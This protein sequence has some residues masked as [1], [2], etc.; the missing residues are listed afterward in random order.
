MKHRN[1]GATSLEQF[2][3]AAPSVRDWA[4]SPQGAEGL[5]GA[6]PKGA[7]GTAGAASR[8]AEGLAGCSPRGKSKLLIMGFVIMVNNHA[9]VANSGQ[10]W[11]DSG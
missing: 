7:D 11:S 4:R 10:Q 9:I 5:G 1:H 3:G 2:G 8:H 6:A